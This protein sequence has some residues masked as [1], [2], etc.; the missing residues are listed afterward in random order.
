MIGETSNFF[1]VTNNTLIQYLLTSSI[2]SERYVN[3]CNQ[4]VS[5]MR[6]LGYVKSKM[7]S[8]ILKIFKN[9]SKSGPVW[10]GGPGDFVAEIDYAGWIA[11]IADS[12]ASVIGAGAGNLRGRSLYDFI[13]RDDRDEVKSVIAAA[14]DP[15]MGASQTPRAEFRLLRLSRAPSRAEILLTHGRRGRITALI[16]NLDEDFAR[17]R[18]ERRV[19]E[20]ISDG[21]AR[22]EKLLA[23]LAHEMKTPL[24]AI[25]G[26]SE[27]MHLE[28]FGPLG[29]G[30]Y[31]DHAGLI[32]SS[33]RHLCLL[34][35]SPSPRDS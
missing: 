26:F 6:R 31:R 25:I 35:T 3:C 19:E 32:H 5:W 22:Q 33:G 12:A 27:A 18:N 21:P 14:M 17:R 2:D 16:R 28:T 1:P 11:D 24:N 23:N 8:N 30:K 10:S 20:G 15:G 34:Y 4:F 29:A 13:H 9:F 7:P